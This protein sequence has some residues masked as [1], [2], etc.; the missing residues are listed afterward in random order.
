MIASL[1]TH[2]APA[3]VAWRPFLDPLPLHNLWW[4]L[5]FPLA[6][7]VSV[8]YKAVSVPDMD[9]Y[10]PQVA[11]MTIQIIVGMLA[12]AAALYVFIEVIVPLYG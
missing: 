11:R 12:L 7:G 6:L 2:G 10:W 8:A 4:V 5:L 1:L 3:L 9:R